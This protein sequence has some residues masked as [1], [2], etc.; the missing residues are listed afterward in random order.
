M[1]IKGLEPLLAA[2]M[3]GKLPS[4][5]VLLWCDREPRAWN[6]YADAVTMPEGRITAKDDLRVLLRL[7]VIL[8]ADCLTAPVV[9][10]LDRVRQFANSVI[11]VAF[12]LAD[13]TV[14]DRENGER[15]L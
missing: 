1:T 11:F 9:E 3:A 6:R 4:R 12:D 10:L 7:D 8:V 14:W 13:G 2:R 5:E 15:A